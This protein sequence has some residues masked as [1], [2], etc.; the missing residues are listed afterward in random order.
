MTKLP[1][2]TTL[3]NASKNGGPTKIPTLP[4][5]LVPRA[6][7]T[8]YSWHAPPNSIYHRQ[9]S[10]PG[11]MLEI[12]DIRLYVVCS[13]VKRASR[14]SKA[15]KIPERFATVPVRAGRNSRRSVRKALSAVSRFSNFSGT[16]TGTG[17]ANVRGTE[18]RGRMRVSSESFMLTVDGV[19]QGKMR[20]GKK[21]KMRMKT[22][23][24][25][26]SKSRC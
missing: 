12:L 22:K 6:K 20:K 23:L 5:S 17:E 18:R 13:P 19:S 14:L 1:L 8:V 21:M 26:D 24:T 3:F 4:G 15:V 16:D 2:P 10:V 9:L 25:A 7:M 11:E